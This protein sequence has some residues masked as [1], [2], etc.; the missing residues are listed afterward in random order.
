MI[1]A[2]SPLPSI[3][4][5]MIDASS[6]T[7]PKLNSSLSLLHTPF[8]SKFR[9]SEGSLLARNTNERAWTIADRDRSGSSAGGG[10]RSGGDRHHR[11]NGGN[12]GRN[13]DNGGRNAVGASGQHD[14][15]EQHAYLGRF[16]AAR[17]RSRCEDRSV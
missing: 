6:T 5:S 4:S 8:Q 17:I 14:D 3:K 11:G 7:A 13:A 1:D 15:L 16:P 9:R 10:V 12:G 2:L